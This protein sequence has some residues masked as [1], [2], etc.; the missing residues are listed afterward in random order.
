M[1]TRTISDMCSDAV[2]LREARDHH[3]MMAR[4]A[5]DELNLVDDEIMRWGDEE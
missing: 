5:I 2:R 3:T 4:C 1:K